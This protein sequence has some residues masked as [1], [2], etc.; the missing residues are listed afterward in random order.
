MLLDA[1][2]V[3]QEQLEQDAMEQQKHNYS[4]PRSPSKHISANSGMHPDVLAAGGW[5]AELPDA[6][7]HG[8]FA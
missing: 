2:K 3:D 8:V 1:I 5:D 6:P 4:D 7:D